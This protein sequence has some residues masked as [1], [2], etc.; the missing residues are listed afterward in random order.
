[1]SK[2]L[3]ENQ[4]RKPRPMNLALYTIRFPVTALISIGHRVSGFFL[5]LAFPWLLYALHQLMRANYQQPIFTSPINRLIFGLVL[6]AGLYHLLA[7]VRHLLMDAGVGESLAA[8]RITAYLV[9]GFFI[10]SAALI[11]VALW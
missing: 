8:A 7:G 2:H 6:L 3:D 5:F 11:G 10:I 4:A 1:M 9:I